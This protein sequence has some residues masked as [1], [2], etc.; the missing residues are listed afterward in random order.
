MKLN[1]TPKFNA[2]FKSVS[3]SF[4]KQ[5]EQEDYKRLFDNATVSIWNEDFT[6]VF[7]QL[8]E[9][10]KLNIPDIKIYLEQNPE[11]VVS[12][13]K[14]LKINRVNKATL[15]LFKAENNQ[16]FLKNLNNTFGKGANTVFIHF[17]E[18]IWN[19]E[20]SFTSEVNYKTLKGEEFPALFSVH[21]PQT[22]LEQQSV[23]ICIQD[24]KKIKVLDIEKKKSL[25]EL[26]QAQ[27]LGKIGS[28]EWNI[29]SDTAICSDEMY[30]MYGVEKGQFKP[31]SS[32]ITKTTFDADKFKL[33]QAKHQLTKGLPV[34]P[35]EYRI[36]TP[37]NEIRY[38]KILALQTSNGK[39]FGVTQDITNIKTTE[40]KLSEA[41]TLA[42]VGSWLYYISSQKI[43][44]SEEIFR[45]WGFDSKLGIPDNDTIISR[46]HEAD[47]NLFYKALD[48]GFKGIPYN[49]EYRINIPNEGQKYIRVICQP[50]VDANGEVVCLTGSTQDITSQK[51][52]EEAQIKDQRLKAIGEMSSSIA[53][54]FNNSLQQMMGNLDII[55]IQENLSE[56]TLERLNS[57]EGI[58]NDVAD[59]VS[60]LQ[61]FSAKDTN[62]EHQKPVDINTLIE[63]VINQSRPLWKDNVEKDGLNI[64]I[65]TEFTETPKI[66]CN[67]GELKSAI[68][69]LIKNSVEA[70]PKG[71]NI[72]IKTHVKNEQIV[73]QFSDTGVGMNDDTK[74][75][76]FEP[77]FTTK[78]FKL[79]RGLGMS[80][81]HNIIKKHEGSIR[82]KDSEINKGTTFEIV[83][84]ISQTSE[85]IEHKRIETTNTHNSYNVLWVDD[86]FLITE[87][88]EILVEEIEHNCSS[89]NSGKDALT[90]LSEN[91][92]DVVF[93]D[94]GM[95]EMNGWELAKEIRA[96]YGDTI[97]II[98]VTGWEIDDATKTQHEIDCVM[99]KP[100]DVI[101]LK[102]IFAEL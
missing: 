53:H 9:L 32:N 87:F 13:L 37:K 52:F 15:K 36:I 96:R 43:E 28:W 14:T 88:A 2:L 20:T 34:E 55:K 23:P 7:K 76:I 33:E 89:V 97:K 74:L 10:K 68:Y 81:V 86:D 54:D 78:G 101:K 63:E 46:V 41:Q 12:L 61:K 47:L 44:W 49:V 71:G 60:A 40:N 48:Q 18:A 56:T 99:Q 16:E 38:L 27:K 4:S 93:T 70:M 19:N 75:K 82:V 65:I 84:P 94:I 62:N 26:K 50:E 73:V 30:R 51:A 72:T 95:P 57:I 35:F 79:G 6:L 90:Y 1:L 67:S 22:V 69:N 64:I 25:F 3:A 42:K 31:T 29:N 45:I 58:I 66:N 83:F 100:F 5:E 59:R 24:I 21:I 102:Q 92:C 91:N 11:V 17:I 8:D 85:T 98:A 77:F 80:G 39:V